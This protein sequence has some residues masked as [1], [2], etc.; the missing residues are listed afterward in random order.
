MLAEQFLN[1]LGVSV[2]AVDPDDK[3]MIEDS[4]CAFYDHAS[5]TL[6]VCNQLCPGRLNYA[7]E[8]VAARL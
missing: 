3:C 4:S 5:R 7:M 2:R 6:T 1:A 8:L